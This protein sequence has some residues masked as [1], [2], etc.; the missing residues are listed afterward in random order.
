MSGSQVICHGH[1]QRYVCAIWR[2]YLKDSAHS[3]ILG[4]GRGSFHVGLYI[5]YQNNL[6]SLGH[7]VGLLAGERKE[8]TKK[9]TTEILFGLGVS[10]KGSE[11]PSLESCKMRVLLLLN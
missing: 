4:G 11:P 1:P 3:Q 10:E 7:L 9:F 6:Q 2:L 8:N 5:K